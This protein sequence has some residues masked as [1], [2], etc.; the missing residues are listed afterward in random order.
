MMMVMVT[1]VIWSMIMHMVVT[2]MV[3]MVKVSLALPPLRI[4]RKGLETLQYPS[5]FWVANIP[6]TIHPATTMLRRL[7]NVK[8][9]KAAAQQSAADL[10]YS[11]LKPLQEEVV[12]QFITDHDVFTV[13][14]TGFG[15]SLC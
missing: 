10:G 2:E 7:V 8:K 1:L 12:D 15:K 6:P 3:T 11:L 13:L 14:S 9:I 4:E 5:L